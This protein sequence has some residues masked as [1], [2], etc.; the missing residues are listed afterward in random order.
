MKKVT[1]KTDKPM[2]TPQNDTE[3]YIAQMYTMH[4]D[5]MKRYVG[6]I[7][8]EFQSRLDG[9]IEVVNGR[10]DGIDKRLDAHTEIIGHVMEDISEIKFDLKK[11]VSYD[12]F[13]KLE[14]RVVIMESF[15]F[16]GRKKK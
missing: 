7:S 16:S 4:N 10:F 13:A 14:K 1:K 11:K 12:D 3:R 15:L 8:E 5:D 6:A 9:V 2:L